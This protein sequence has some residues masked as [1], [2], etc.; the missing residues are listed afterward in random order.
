MNCDQIAYKVVITQQH[1][2]LRLDCSFMLEDRYCSIY[3]QDNW[4]RKFVQPCQ[5]LS[6]W[7]SAAVSQRRLN[8][9]TISMATKT[10][11]LLPATQTPNPAQVAVQVKFVTVMA[12]VNPVQASSKD[13]HPTTLSVAQ[14]QIGVVLH[15]CLSV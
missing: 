2:S 14:I 12:F 11:V 8:S 7:F 6:C 15:A 9:A 13:L 10:P 4:A 5:I 3:V 1:T